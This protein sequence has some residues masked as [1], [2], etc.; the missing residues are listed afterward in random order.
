MPRMVRLRLE[1]I[2]MDFLWGGGVVVWKPHLVRWVTVCLDK[3]K[4]RLWVKCL[5][6]LNKA[7]LYKW[8]WRFANE[9]EAFWNQVIKGKYGKE[10]GGWCSREVREGY[11]VGLW[12]VIR[13]NWH[14]VSS[15]LSF[16]VGYRRRVKF[17]KDK[18][19]GATP[20]CDFF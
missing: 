14:L 17:W 2:Q 3:R 9:K 1:Q 11:G 6:T 16:M 12:K 4:G 15:R 5:S 7:L 8:S 18:W 10:R 19:C 20:L 13:K